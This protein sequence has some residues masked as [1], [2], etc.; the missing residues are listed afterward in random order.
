MHARADEF[1]E[2]VMASFLFFLLFTYAKRY[3]DSK[4]G[5]SVEHSSRSTALLV[6]HRKISAWK[7]SVA[8]MRKYPPNALRLHKL[9]TFNICL[10]NDYVI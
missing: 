8:S 7:L 2:L 4:F 6:H 5:T 3:S 10:C 9:R 1:V